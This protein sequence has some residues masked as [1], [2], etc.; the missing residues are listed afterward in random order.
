MTPLIS[1]IVPVYKVEKVLHSCIESILQQTYKNFE[2]LLID[3]GSPDKSGEICDSYAEKD[4]RIKVIHKKNEGVSVAR[5]TGFDNA[6]GEYIV[7]VDS[8]DYVNEC[9]LQDFIDVVNE[10]PEAQMVWCGFSTVKDY[11]KTVIENIQYD[12]S[13]EKIIITDISDIMTLHGK[14][15]DSSPWNKLYKKDIIVSNNLRM[16][17]TISLGEDL[18]FNFSYMD[19]CY[20]KKIYFL[21]KKNYNYITVNNESLNSKF[22]ISMFELYKYL[23][24]QMYAFLV[25]W[26]IDSKQMKLYYNFAYYSYLRCFENTFHS[27][28]TY[29]SNK[30]RYKCNKRILQSKE[31]KE[32][33]E[34]SNC[35]ILP[36]LKLAYKTNSYW[37]VKKCNALIKFISDIKHRR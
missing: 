34:K 10:Y 30:E 15:L 18:L 17:K 19:A 32:A 16:D 7:C 4:E 31:F 1:V 12:T 37:L 14:W 11:E 20:N 9:Y 25:K 36:I 26:N 35:H 22:Y 13:G 23:N 6:K 2:L 24:S 29:A 33:V 5:N 27:K 28:S 21:N 8:D 3:D